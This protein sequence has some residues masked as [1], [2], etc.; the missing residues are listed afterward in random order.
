MSDFRKFRDI[1][2]EHFQKMCDGASMLYETNVD[3]DV[4]WEIYLN[5]FPDGVNPMYRVRR[6]YDCSCCRH[7]IK[8][9]GNVV[10]LKDG[11]I[12]SIWDVDVGDPD[13]QPVADALSRY[14][15]SFPVS[16]VYH[17]VERTIGTKLSR[18]LR[19]GHTEQYNHFY[20]PIPER[21]IDRFRRSDG[22]YKGQHRDIR[23]VFKRSLDE[24]DQ[25]NVLTVLELIGQNSL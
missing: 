18:S 20:L 19:D 11:V 7:F 6:E 9:I 3:N 12:E 16:D 14:V 2:E 22:D 13:F 25:G 17:T 21:F 4:L 5:S 23:N 24:I 8:T 10:T 1:I 15:K